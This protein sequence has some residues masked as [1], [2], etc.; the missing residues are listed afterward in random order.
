MTNTG[1]Q[2]VRFAILL[3]LLPGIF[4][5]SSAL[6]QE[7]EE[8]EEAGRN[9]IE[10]FAGGTFFEGNAKASMGASYERRI[11]EHTGIGIL[12]ENTAAEEWVFAVPVRLYIKEPWVTWIAPGIERA[13]GGE[14]DDDE[15]LVRVGTAVEF[16]FSGW[17]FAPEINFD[18]V[19]HEVKTVLGATVGWKF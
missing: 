10:I 13:Y 5:A 9:S 14:E 4:T 15:F 8:T 17:T 2:V 6:A 12:A 7:T 3:L 1:I 19:D 16:E 11:S 18:F